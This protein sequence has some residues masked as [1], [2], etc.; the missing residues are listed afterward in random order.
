MKAGAAFLLKPARVVQLTAAT[1]AAWYDNQLAM[2]E[3]S[4]AKGARFISILQ[5]SPYSSPFDHPTP[6]SPMCMT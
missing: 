2:A 5:P 3:L 4:K 6:T 1:A